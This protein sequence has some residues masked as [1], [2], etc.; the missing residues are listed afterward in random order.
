MRCFT[1]PSA[2]VV[3]CLLA[4]HAHAVQ[5]RL[6]DDIMA[7][8]RAFAAQV[9]AKVQGDDPDKSA[10]LKTVAPDLSASSQWRFHD[11]YRSLLIAIP[12]TRPLLA[13]DKY[14][15]EQAVVDVV[16]RL[17]RQRGLSGPVEV[18]FIEP[19]PAPISPRCPCPAPACP[20]GPAMIPA[21]CPCP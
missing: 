3:T 16:E 8:P 17:I 1:L 4:G 9:E 15:G 7:D 11:H 6:V 20:C 14:A 5:P 19:E 12:V 18:V 2:V 13:A 10:V 21:A